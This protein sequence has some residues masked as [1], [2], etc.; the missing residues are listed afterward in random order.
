M[1]NIVKENVI[2]IVGG[3]GPQ[4]G[5]DLFSYILSHT[6]ASTD[7]EHLPVIVMS[8]PG[9]LGDRTAFLEGS[10]RTNPAYNIARIIGKLESAGANIIGIACNTAHVPGIFN[11]IEDELAKKN[12]RVTLMNMPY[13]TCRHIKEN[14]PE[15]R[16]VGIMVTN[17]TYRSG[18]YENLLDRFG[19]ELIVPDPEFQSEV[20]HKLIYDPEFGLKANP[21]RITREA[22]TLM[23]E[24]TRFFRERETEAIVLG[25]T[26]LSPMIKEN[27]AKG[28]LLVDSSEALALAMI[29]EAT[30][31]AAVR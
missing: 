5:I 20:I 4:A 17:G 31:L 16:R 14:Y 1:D 24:A 7:Q 12:S 21:N 13:E 27:A 25:C 22:R 9:H 15:I 8:L 23:D 19:Y 18:I 2:G 30:I 28:I 3:M 6:T 26:D 11:V 29:R 10:I